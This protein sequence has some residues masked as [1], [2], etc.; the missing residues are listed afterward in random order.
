MFFVVGKGD[1]PSSFRTSCMA[2]CEGNDVLPIRFFKTILKSNLQRLKIPNKFAMRYGAGLPNPVFINP[3]DGTQWKVYWSKQNGEVWFEKGWKEFVQH[4]SLDLG[5]L[6]F[7]KY[8]GTSQI[9]VLILNKS[10]LEIN[11]PSNSCDENDNIDHSDD[12]SVVILDEWPDQNAKQM[13]GENPTQRTS[14]LNWPKKTRA[15][16]VA[17]NFISCNPFFTVFIRA[18]CLRKCRLSVPN[19]EGVVENKEKYAM[20]LLG[21]RSW[22]VKLLPTHKLLMLRCFSAGW[23]LFARENELQPGDV[24]VFELINTEDLVFKVHVYRRHG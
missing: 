24:C 21:E 5:H 23:S 15:Q 20:L 18:S 19:L 8:E 13:R 6:I 22:K 11:Y 12:E 3:P 9:D 16:E 7:F 14:S 17:R 4:Y 10:A 2:A 1:T